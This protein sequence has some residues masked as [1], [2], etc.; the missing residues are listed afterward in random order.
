MEPISTWNRHIWLDAIY[1]SQ[2][3][4]REKPAQIPL[5][6]QIYHFAC[7]SLV[8]LGLGTDDSMQCMRFIDRSHG[9]NDE[10]SDTGHEK[11][12]HSFT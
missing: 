12:V 8:W 10:P 9:H 7:D 4:E 3:N 1:G 5:M 11:L 6:S 2:R